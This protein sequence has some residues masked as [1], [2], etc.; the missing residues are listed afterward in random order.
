MKT[1]Q[2]GTNS[3]KDTE[4]KININM[5]PIDGYHMADIDWECLV[6]TERAY[7]K[8]IVKK[9]DAIRVDDDNYKITIDS[10]LI[11]AGEYYVTLTAYIPDADFPDGLR[12]EIRTAFTGVTIDA[13]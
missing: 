7:K 11:G 8:I 13:K 4:F 6:F 2:L 5:T 10:A 1:N 12:T 9:S 3:V